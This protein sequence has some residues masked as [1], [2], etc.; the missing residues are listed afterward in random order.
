[1]LE[2]LVYPSSDF[3]GEINEMFVP[4]G[5]RPSCDPVD[6]QLMSEAIGNAL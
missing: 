1:M 3:E 4:I 2:V 5:E 6:V